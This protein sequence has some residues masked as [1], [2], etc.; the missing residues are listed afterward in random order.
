M[1]NPTNTFNIARD[2]IK[3]KEA[4]SKLQNKKIEIVQKII[5]G[6]D[7][8]KPKLNMTT[9]R[10]S[11]KQVVIP[12]NNNS[13]IGF[14]KDLSTHVVNINRILKNIKSST[15]ADFICINNKGIII[16]TNNI[17]SLLDLQTIEQYVK[18]TVYVEPEQV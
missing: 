18:S 5:N 7:K 11:C 12:I 6:Q 13:A 2:T 8:P 9:K 16:T 17:A 1:A 15:M 4:F 10:L 14:I 3:I